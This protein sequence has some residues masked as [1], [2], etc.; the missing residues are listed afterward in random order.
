MPPPHLIKTWLRAKENGTQQQK[1][2]RKQQTV[3]FIMKLDSKVKSILMPD[4]PAFILT[5]VFTKKAVTLRDY[6]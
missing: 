6:H 4:K 3:V 2:I 1:L 5:P